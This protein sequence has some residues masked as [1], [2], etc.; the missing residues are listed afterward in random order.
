MSW[1]PPH[2][3]KQIC[4]IVK[5]HQFEPRAV[6]YFLIAF[7]IIFTLIFLILPVVII[8]QQAFSKG[9]ACYIKNLLEADTLAAIRLT[10]IAATTAVVINTIFGL[11]AA[12]AVTRFNFRGK[13]ILISLIDIPFMV[14]PVVSGLLFVLLFGSK[15][16]F[17]GILDDLN[18]KIIFSTPGI[19]LATCFVTFPFVAR[20][21][22]PIMQSMGS[23]FEEAALV[24]GARPLKMFLRVT[25][26][27]IKWGLL[28]GVM[29]CSARAIGEFG[30]VSVV[31]GHIRGSTNT[32][33]LHVEILYNE[34]NF[35]GAFS[36]AS[37]LM[38]IAIVSLILRSFVENKT[39]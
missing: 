18:L 23:E 17:G 13:N 37:I 2:N 24:L 10:L 36:V 30:A 34:Y 33:P 5:T 20:E 32:I 19:I 9:I 6:R 26:P 15:G 28:Y 25:L 38:I 7:T 12:Y 3:Q 4:S 31:S 29:L 27:S 1:Y 11:T 22:M 21:L 8:F 39:S 16:W 14:S 35:A